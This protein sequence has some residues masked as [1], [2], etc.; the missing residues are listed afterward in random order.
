MLYDYV[1]LPD[2]KPLRWPHGARV[3]LIFYHQRGILGDDP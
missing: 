1:A 3:A 2:R